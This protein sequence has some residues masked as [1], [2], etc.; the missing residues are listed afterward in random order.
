MKIKKVNQLDNQRQ[1][2]KI[3]LSDP[4]SLVNLP[5]N[6]DQRL[7]KKK[8]LYGDYIKKAKIL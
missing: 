1:K 3:N 4:A 5:D 2:K 7:D 6:P 8:I